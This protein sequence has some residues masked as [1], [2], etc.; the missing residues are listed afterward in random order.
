MAFTRG[1]SIITGVALTVLL[2]R[3]LDVEGYGAYLF[4]LTIA[5]MLAMPVLLGLP[6]LLMRQIAIYRAEQDVERLRGVIRWSFSFAAIT[7]VAV[8]ISF[9]LYILVSG[10]AQG[11]LDASML[12]YVL[13]LPLVGA[14]AFMRLSSSI[15]QGFE[16]PFWS[17]LPDGTI[18]PVLLLAFVAIAIGLGQLTPLWAMTLHVAAAVAALAWAAVMVLRYCRIDN[19][20]STR[21]RRVETRSWLSSLLPLGLIAAAAI[22]NTR[23]DIFM[24]GA[25]ASVTEVAFYGIASQIAGLALIGQTILNTIIAPKIARYH[26]CGEQVQLEQVAVNAAR[27]A[28]VGGVAVLLMIVLAGDDILSMLVGS[29]Y[30][31]AAGIAFILA[32]GYAVSAALGP[33]ALTLNMTGHERITA[34]IVWISA[35]LNAV[36]NAAAIPFFGAQGAAGATVISMLLRQTAMTVYLYRTLQMTS[37]VLSYPLRKAHS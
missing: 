16:R 3:F 35:A 12:L 23:L 25:L 14:L 15:L 11:G 28:T 18:R 5:Q 30:A 8:A 31:D 34:R 4:A 33:V 26:K 19:L 27:L 24:I 29:A 17:S 1:V 13:T 37:G 2:G 10:Q 32:A 9:G 20:D 36:L 21:K 22:I 7:L 6:T